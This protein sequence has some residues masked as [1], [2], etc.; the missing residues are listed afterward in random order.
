MNKTAGD[1]NTNLPE[2]K[3][4]NLGRLSLIFAVV[5]V[6]GLYWRWLLPG[7]ITWGDWFYLSKGCMVDLVPSLWSTGAG[8]GAFGAYTASS[9][10][11]YPII[12]LQGFICRA[13]NLDF[14]VIERLI[15]FLPL[16]GFLIFSPYY[17][18]RTLG[19]GSIAAA[20]MILVFNLSSTV[21]LNANVALLALSDALAPLVLA[22]FIRMVWHPNLRRGVWF[23]LLLALQVVIE[24]R[25]CYITLFFCVLYLI[26]FLVFEQQI[27]KAL[28]CIIKTL[29]F[30]TVL[31][32][33][34]HSYWIIPLFFSKAAGSEA[35]LLP[36]GYT[37]AEALKSLSYMT[38]LH[39]LG[40][41]LPFWGDKDIVN[42]AQAQFLFLPILAFSILLFGRQKKMM[43]FFALSALIFSFLVKGSKPPFG[44]INIWLFLH[45]PGFFM[46]RA[47]GKWYMP[48]L[49]S[50]AA[51]VA[52]WVEE[53]I[54]REWF[55]QALSYLKGRFKLREVLAKTVTVV[56]ILAIV[57]IVFPVQPF[58]ALKYSAIFQPYPVPAESALFESFF[59]SQNHFFRI[60]WIPNIYRF[61]YFSTQ[62]RA[63]MGY[64]LGQ[65][66]LSGLRSGDPSRWSY[67]FSYL[68]KSFT[69]KL[70]RLLSISYI[71]LPD[72]DVG[73]PFIYFWLENPPQYYHD[74]IKATPK[75]VKL[76]YPGKSHVYEFASPLPLFYASSEGYLAVA[77]RDMVLPIIVQS[78]YLD[79]KPAL[80][81]VE[82]NARLSDCL[83][84][85]SGFIIQ[86]GSPAD[87]AL[88]FSRSVR[89]P[90]VIY[91]DKKA[92]RLKTIIDK[93]GDFE[94]WLDCSKIKLG[95]DSSVP[96]SIEIN[97][98]SIYGQQANSGK[99]LDYLKYLKLAEI[100]LKAGK[101]KLVIRLRGK[102]VELPVSG[103]IILVVRR[104]RERS[105]KFVVDK[106]RQS[107]RGVSYIFSQSSEFNIE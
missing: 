46:F 23:G 79:R 26:Y 41:S 60:L 77:N 14:A 55:V 24:V 11:F 84:S 20:A 6:I 66:I 4:P 96:L 8:M 105:A 74:L 47:P 30:S 3:Y 89:I 16:V 57:F 49:I 73:H 27:R 88:E 12:I 17:L 48:L 36:A 85:A 7:A 68:G 37:S 61:G 80:T 53:I 32:I 81:I 102:D 69:P 52:C 19:F 44:C 2:A 21:F 72:A 67:L 10:P 39:S 107:Q 82:Q 95:K 100:S 62:H 97:G 87:L 90:F 51:L 76:D 5:M 91:N 98:K 106:I 93:A 103:E 40:I 83:L 65:G 33:L 22:L 78:D 54:L 50:Y 29:F 45:F 104:E 42:P 58:S 56:L 1:K 34:L 63:I 25:G 101:S 99:G 75:L 13:L 28:P 59:H 86:N 92:Q 31:V 15:I 70:L 43:T 94:L 35:A 64:Y 18:A 9:A 38:L 71:A